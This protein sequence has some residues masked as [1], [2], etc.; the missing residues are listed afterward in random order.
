MV[1]R[2][3]LEV[4]M[5]FMR[6]L[7]ER[8]YVKMLE[9]FVVEYTDGRRRLLRVLSDCLSKALDDSLPFPRRIR[10]R[11]EAAKYEARHRVNSEEANSVGWQIWN[12]TWFRA[13]SMP[14]CMSGC[15]LSGGSMSLVVVCLYRKVE[16]FGTCRVS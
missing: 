13:K 11:R 16:C 12:F 3:H 10:V 9:S 5:H 2:S 4:D 8:N 1:L 15:P 6:D 7:D 14:S